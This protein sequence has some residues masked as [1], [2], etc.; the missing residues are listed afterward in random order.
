MTSVR[1][2]ECFEK[3][4]LSFS[5][6]VIG[7]RGDFGRRGMCQRRRQHIF[8]HE[9]MRGNGMVRNPEDFC[10]DNKSGIV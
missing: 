7:R 1:P 8:T 3:I 9:D 2:N 4:T 6:K 10:H 5:Q